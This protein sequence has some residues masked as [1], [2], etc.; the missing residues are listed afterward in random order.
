MDEEKSLINDS[1]LVSIFQILNESPEMTATEVMERVREKGILLAP[2]VGSMQSEYLGPMIEREIDVLNQ[3]GLLPPMPRMLQE[4]KGQYK[5]SY[6][7]P[8]SRAQKAEYASGA[9]RSLEIFAQYASQTGDTSALDIIDMHTAGPEI[10]EIYGTPDHWINTPQKIAQIQAQKV[11]QQNMQTAIQ[12]APAH[13]ALMKAHAA[14]GGELPSPQNP[15]GAP[16]G[17]RPQVPSQARKRR[18]GP[19]GKV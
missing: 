4:A 16:A 2:T 3:Q 18:Q 11:K 15:T 10:A 19:L 7:S 1:F 8:I 6:D 5:V 12:A 17:Q 14:M 9:T 13:A